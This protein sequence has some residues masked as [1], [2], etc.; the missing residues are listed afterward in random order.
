MWDYETGEF[1]RTLKGHTDS[2]QD[3]DFD[4]TGKLLVSCSADLTVKLW[5]VHEG[6]DCVKNMH[7]YYITCLIF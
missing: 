6:F 7:G 4:H 3:L 2:V 5:D 1:E